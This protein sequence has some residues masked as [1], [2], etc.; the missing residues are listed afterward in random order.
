MTRTILAFLPVEILCNIL[1]H[2]DPRDRSSAEISCDYFMATQGSPLAAFA[3]SL[4]NRLI[5][6]A[7]MEDP[8][9]S[10]LLCT[11]CQRTHPRSVYLY[12]KMRSVPHRWCCCKEAAIELG[13]SWIT[14]ERI[15]GLVSQA[16][17]TR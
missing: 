17:S 14:P 4:W 9:A 3:G 8:N 5:Y 12:D 1:S 2:L 11:V 13:A 16:I 10:E 7:R 6:K 15:R